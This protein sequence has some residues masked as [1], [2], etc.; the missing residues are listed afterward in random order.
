MHQSEAPGETGGTLAH[1]RRSSLERVLKTV[2]LLGR[3]GDATDTLRQVAIAVVDVLEFGAAAINVTTAAGD[4]RVDAVVGPPGLGQLLGRS[5]PKAD[6]VRVLGACEVWG[7]LRFLAHGGDPELHAGLVTWTPPPGELLDDDAWHPD[8]GLFAPLVDSRGALLGVLSV[9]LPASGRRPDLEQRTLLEMF[10]A[11]AA[12][13][14]EVANARA[15]LLDQEI[16]YRTVFDE[17]PVPAVIADAELNL[18]AVNAAAVELLGVPRGVL[19]G[20]GLEELVHGEDAAGVTATCR[21][22]LAGTA[23]SGTVVH[24][25]SARSDRSGPAGVERR[26]A[27][28]DDRRLGS[29]GAAPGAAAGDDQARAD[30]RLDAP[31]WL[32]TSLSR[33]D[34]ATTG[35]RLVLNLEDVTEDRRALAEMRH[36]AD[37]DVLTG[38][39]NRRALDERMAGALAAVGPGATVALLS[40]DLDGFKAVNDSHGHQVGDDILVL[41]TRRLTAVLRP[42]DFLARLGGDEFVVV[43]TV[44]DAPVA[45]AIAERLVRSMDEVFRV[46]PVQARV[47]LSAGVAVAPGAGTAPGPLLAAAD[48]ALYTAKDLG[49][50]RWFLSPAAGSPPAGRRRY[51]RR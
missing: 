9:D 15:R 39:P 36:L 4:L 44:E 40:C 37:H 25:L 11:E 3:S 51:R 31:L 1:V 18:V 6:W 41:A 14:I 28:P 2:H 43:A 34:G 29:G 30:R 42:G 13:A 33:I 23:T 26:T 49:R 48:A 21:A 16:L 45:T 5:S 32:R 17:A 24:R 8:D 10:A 35:P 19:V 22:A 46:G 27:G 20:I 50:A 47:S 12:A 38:L 7:D